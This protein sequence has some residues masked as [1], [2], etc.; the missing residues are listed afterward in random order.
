MKPDRGPAPPPPL[1]AND[2]L[3]AVAGTIAWAVALVVLLIVRSDL[4][5]RER[6]LK[7]PYIGCDGLPNSG[8]A[9]VRRGLLTATIFVPPNSGTA[10]EML[11]QA[12]QSGTM[13]VERSTIAPVSIPALDALAAAHTGKTRSLSAGRT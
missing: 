2:Q 3:V 11:A 12:I 10:L 9:W 4:P 7:L 1:E 5:A 6:W 13:P 8:Q